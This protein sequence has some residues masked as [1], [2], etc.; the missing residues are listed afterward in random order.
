MVVT[1]L[2]VAGYVGFRALFREQPDIKPDVD[3]L[4]CVAYLQRA[5][6]A[7]VHP[8]ELPAGWRANAVHFER[9]AP[10]Q[11]RLGVLTDDEEFIG[12]VQ[13]E[14]DVDDLLAQYVD[15]S[16]TQG[17]DVSP[18]NE[19]DATDWQTWSDTGGDHA[20]S[21]ELT[22]GPLAGQT[23]LVYGSAPV[24]QQEA[25]LSSLTLAPVGTTVSAAD[26]DTDELQ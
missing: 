8:Q 23:V 20:F 6:V 19:L 13:Q 16:P 12:V 24:A 3:Y 15:K 26:C 1:V 2:F 9:G 10:P 25:F 11:W 18:Q 14:G 22:S 7:I 17:D 5:D 21:T 4:S